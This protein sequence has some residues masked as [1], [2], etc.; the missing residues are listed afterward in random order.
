LILDYRPRAIL[1]AARFVLPAVAVLFAR[2]FV[3]GFGGR[4]RA[5]AIVL[6]LL[7]AYALVEFSRARTRVWL[8]ASS[9]VHIE[10]RLGFGR[11]ERETMRLERITGVTVTLRRCP[12]RYVPGIITKRRIVLRLREGRVLPISTAWEAGD[13]SYRTGAVEALRVALDVARPPRRQSLAGAPVAPRVPKLAA[14]SSSVRAGRG[15]DVS[16]S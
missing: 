9:V 8:E 6:G 16:R 11:T 3:G 2:V 13:I 14:G 1:R 7:G 10:W 15:V 4:E 5:G 12:R